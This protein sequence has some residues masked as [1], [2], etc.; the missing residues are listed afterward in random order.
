MG[1]AAPSDAAV[2][3]ATRHWLVTA[4]IGLNLCPF[5]KAVHVKHQIH[6]A[7]SHATDARAARIDLQR[8]LEALVAAPPD[9]RDTTLLIL[10]KCF[11]DFLEFNEFLGV[12]DRLLARLRLRGEIQIASFHPQYEFADVAPGDISHYTNRAPYPILHLLRE[13]SVEKAVLAFPN[14]EAIYEKNIETMRRLGEA[15]WRSLGISPAAD[16]APSGYRSGT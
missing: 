3:A 1:A 14:A 5:A 6:Y 15:G 10:P 11:L 4:V 13:A 8:E 16:D 2:I 7:V 12:A 9:A